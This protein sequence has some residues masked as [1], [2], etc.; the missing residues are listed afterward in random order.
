[1]LEAAAVSADGRAQA[2]AAVFADG[3]GEGRKEG[4]GIMGN[5]DIR[6]LPLIHRVAGRRRFTHIRLKM[7]PS[8]IT[9]NP[10][11]HLSPWSQQPASDPLRPLSPTLILTR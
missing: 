7:T 1:M 11:P 10:L 2:V 4:D 6:T 5:G 3:R 9:A 8:R